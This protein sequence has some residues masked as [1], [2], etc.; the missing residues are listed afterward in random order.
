M[1]EK[2]VGELFASSVPYILCQELAFSECVF[3]YILFILTWRLHFC[4]DEK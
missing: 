3:I 2:L 1:P 4:K